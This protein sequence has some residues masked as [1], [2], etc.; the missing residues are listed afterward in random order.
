MNTISVHLIMNV[1]PQLHEEHFPTLHTMAMDYL[2]I[3]ASLVS[4]K[5]V[6][7]SSSKTGAITSIVC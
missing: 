5:R 1:T 7:L 3:Q 2:P 4:C 6:F